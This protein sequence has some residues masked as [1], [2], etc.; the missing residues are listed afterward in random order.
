MLM[1]HV[2]NTGIWLKKKPVKLDKKEN[3][4]CCLWESGKR[5][6][7]GPLVLILSLLLQLEFLKTIASNALSKIKLT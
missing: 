1:I 6:D 5:K 7:E 3:G 4:K 2:Y